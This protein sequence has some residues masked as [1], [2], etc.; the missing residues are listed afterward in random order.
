MVLFTLM[1]VL[2]FPTFRDSFGQALQNVPDSIKPILGEA[3]DYQRING[4][5]EIQVFMQMIFL[6]F[7]YGIILFSSLIAGEENDGTLQS[8]LAQPISRSKAYFQK[9]AAGSVMLGIVSFTL[10]AT[11]WIG[12]VAIGEHTLYDKFTGGRKKIPKPFAQVFV[13]FVNEQV[14]QWHK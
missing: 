12:V 14:D 1:V 5:L 7:I 10:F 6:T 11:T 3:S 4:F 13:V 9:L 8:L 2:L